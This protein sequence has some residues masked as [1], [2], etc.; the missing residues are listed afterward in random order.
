MCGCLIAF[1]NSDM[2][3][4]NPLKA[5]AKHP[6]CFALLLPPLLLLLLPPN[7][8]RSSAAAAAVGVPTAAAAAE[9]AW[10]LGLPP[11]VDVTL[12]LMCE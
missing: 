4:P 6:R 9:L 7:A 5:V 10:T 2:L 1:Q 12:C 11:G 8:A 3:N